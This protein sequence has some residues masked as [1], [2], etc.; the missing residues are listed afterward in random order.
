MIIHGVCLETRPVILYSQM[1]WMQSKALAKSKDELAVSESYL[2]KTN[3][4]ITPI[5][6]QILNLFI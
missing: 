5:A 4:T 6:P 1:L 2:E 3:V